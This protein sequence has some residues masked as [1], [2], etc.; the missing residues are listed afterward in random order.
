MPLTSATDFFTR[1]AMNPAARAY[2]SSPAVNLAVGA[3][4]GSRAAARAAAQGLG[5]ILGPINPY[6]VRALPALGAN[7]ALEETR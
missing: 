4:A 5:P 7:A 2:T 3:Q 1:L 6:L